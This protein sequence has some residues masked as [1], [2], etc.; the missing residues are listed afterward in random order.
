VRG[1]LRRKKIGCARCAPRPPCAPPRA[2]DD[3]SASDELPPRASHF[4]IARLG[5]AIP[6]GSAPSRLATVGPQTYVVGFT[7]LGARGSSNPLPM[8]ILR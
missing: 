3:L 8:S 4:G 5:V 1:A 6:R 7:G 2:A